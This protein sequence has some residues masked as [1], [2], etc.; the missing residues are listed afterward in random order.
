[1]ATLRSHLTG[2]LEDLTEW[3]ARLKAMAD[4]DGFTVVASH[5]RLIE[6]ELKLLARAIGHIPLETVEEKIRLLHMELTW[7]QNDLHALHKHSQA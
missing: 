2:A 6:A 7:L 4:R 1:L 3:A 5:A